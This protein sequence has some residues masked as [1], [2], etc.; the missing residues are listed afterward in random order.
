MENIN[1]QYYYCRA[2]KNPF[3]DIDYYCKCNGPFCKSCEEEYKKEL[4][5]KEC[6]KC[7]T[8]EKKELIMLKY[9]AD[10]FDRYQ[11]TLKELLFYKPIL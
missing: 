10:L 8:N 7:T 11:K 1:S 6:P 5:D 4:G 2:C 3:K 9:K